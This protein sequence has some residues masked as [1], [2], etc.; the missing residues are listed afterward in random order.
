MKE[1]GLEQAG[2]DIRPTIT[3]RE[4]AKLT[5]AARD[6]EVEGTA[7]L[8]VI[9]GADG[10]LSDLL[11]LRGLPYGVTANC[12]IAL[13]KCKFTPAMKDGKPVSVRTSVEFEFKTYR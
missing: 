5:P 2:G 3:H 12:L 4:N 6:H 1:L 8:S 13:K 10:E 11:V 7:I 9:V